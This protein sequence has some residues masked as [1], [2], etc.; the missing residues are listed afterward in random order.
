MKRFP[1]ALAWIAIL[2][3]LFIT[4]PYTAAAAD[5]ATWE[6]AT[7]R[8]CPSHRLEWICDGCYD[9]LL[10]DF[11]QKLPED[12]QAKILAIA[13]YTHRCAKEIAGFS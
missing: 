5:L 2:L 12:A 11:E 10:S 13:D 3:V 7:H 9:D 1:L 6:A 8:R 4:P